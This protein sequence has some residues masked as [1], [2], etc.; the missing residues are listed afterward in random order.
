MIN[1]SLIKSE[2]KHINIDKKNQINNNNTSSK[3]A[4][5][6]YIDI[7]LLNIEYILKYLE[8]HKEQNNNDNMNF[9]S[10]LSIEK[11]TKLFHQEELFYEQ[12][13]Q[14]LFRKRFIIQLLIVL[15]SFL[16]P[17]NKY[18][19]E[20]FKFSQN[21]RDSIIN[22][23]KNCILYLKK[24]YNIYIYDLMQNEKK[25]AKWKENNNLE[26][27]K[28][29]NNKEIKDNK[30]SKENKENNESKENNQEDLNS[31]IIEIKNKFKN[32]LNKE[33]EFK[34]IDK[35]DN[36]KE[37]K[38]ENVKFSASMDGLSNEIPF[39]GQY[40]EEI[41][42]D[43][44]PDEEIEENNNKEKIYNNNPS[45]TW[46]FL[47]L[48]SEGDISRIKE[49]DVN[50]LLAISE[51]YY[52]QFHESDAK[53]NFNFRNLPELK[54]KNSPEKE[55]LNPIIINDN[56]DKPFIS[57]PK[58]LQNPK[59]GNNKTE[60]NQNETP[61]LKFKLKEKISENDKKEEKLINI[62]NGDINKSIK[63]NIDIKKNILKETK[64]ITNDISKNK[65]IKLKEVI[66]DKN[67]KLEMKEAKPKEVI[68]DVNKKLENLQKKEVINISK[69]N[70]KE[71]EKE[72]DKEKNKEKDGKKL[73]TKN[74][75]I[76]KE[77]LKEKNNDRQNTNDSN[78]NLNKIKEKPV[79]NNNINNIPNKNSNDKEKQINS[80]DNDNNSKEK[81]KLISSN[82]NDNMTK[83]I[84]KQISNNISDNISKDK[85]K[86]VKKNIANLIPSDTVNISNDPKSEIISLRETSNLEHKD[87]TDN[88]D[89]SKINPINN[90]VPNMNSNLNISKNNN[91]DLKDNNN[92]M[93]KIYNSRPNYNNSRNNNS[94]YIRNDNNNYRKYNNHDHNH[95]NFIHKKTYRDN[96]NS[97]YSGKKKKD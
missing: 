51:K 11:Y 18:Q 63:D 31:K 90:K 20:K 83:D 52:N 27:E 7:F 21:Q 36:L 38:K 80:N 74:E 82:S 91:K 60:N 28:I 97:Y 64:D 70:D 10:W 94:N 4:E 86:Q 1:Q 8:E 71:K 50:K 67:L 87:H 85:G 81:I 78:T 39:F 13:K 88:K 22:I 14:P 43:L 56:K 47:R 49:D 95:S 76:E 54:P 12:I 84:G 61:N 5:I 25:W 45:F 72:N 24:K 34:F 41:Y 92:K 42:K 89:N 96:N 77:K 65:E 23:I 46:K 6:S 93:H 30:D 35:I 37:T 26:L 33:S 19:T 66:K 59:N 9:E 75:S 58:E 3:Q 79:I 48:L 32:Y 68:T 17:I 69:E 40:L 15:N 57:L 73:E 16:T 62:S 55:S 53:I 2:S 29:L 44:D